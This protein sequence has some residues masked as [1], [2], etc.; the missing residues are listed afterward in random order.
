[1]SYDFKKEED[2][3][4][5]IKNLGIEY[6]FGC[7]NEKDAQTCQL[8][9]DYLETIENNPDKAAKIYKENCDERNFG[10]SCYKYAAYVE[11]NNLKNLKPVIPEMIRY[12][13]K[14][15]EYNWSDGCFAAGMKLHYHSDSITDIDE[16]TNNL[17]QSL[18]YLEKACNNKHS[19]ACYV[20]SNIHF[21]GIEEIGL[22]PNKSKFLEYS[23]KACDQNEL[24]GCVNASIVY[25]K[26][27]GVPKDLDLAQ[28]Y[29]ERALDIQRQIQE[30]KGIKFS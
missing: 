25:N 5:Y 27:D 3:K 24:K 13:K 10:R 11:K 21:S 23:I 14:G 1:M 4:E 12:F 8:L 29:K 9:G 19:E 16:R 6:R 2:V 15:C 22:K 20:A 26:G 17:L 28:K 18:Q 30:E 7:F